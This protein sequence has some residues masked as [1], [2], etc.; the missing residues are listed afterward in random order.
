MRDV[1]ALPAGLL[2]AIR[3]QALE[4]LIAFCRDGREIAVRTGLQ[5]LD[6]GPL[7]LLHLLP[8]RHPGED[9]RIQH[10]LQGRD[11]EFGAAVRQAGE[12]ELVVSYYGLRAQLDAL[13]AKCAAALAE[14][15]LFGDEGVVEAAF[16]GLEEAVGFRLLVGFAVVLVL[17]FQEGFYFF[18]VLQVR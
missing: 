14:V 18:L 10:H 13:L 7:D 15:A 16:A 1:P 6:V 12:D 2:H 8:L 17:P 11:A 3:I 4:N 5:P 9:N